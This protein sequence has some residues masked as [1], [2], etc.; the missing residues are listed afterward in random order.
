MLHEAVRPWVHGDGLSYQLNYAWDELETV[1]RLVPGLEG[2]EPY[3]RA[4]RK[5]TAESNEEM[6]RLVD[7]SSVAFEEG[8][9]SNIDAA[10]I[11]EFCED[12]QAQMLSMRNRFVAANVER[13]MES[14]NADCSSGPVLMPQV[15]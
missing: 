3:R 12:S 1:C 5:L 15:H 14:I 7:E 11:R 10:A 8:Q 2:A 4:L 13:L 9:R 6:F